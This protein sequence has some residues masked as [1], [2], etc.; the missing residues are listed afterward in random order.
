M[1][2]CLIVTL[3]VISASLAQSSDV[4]TKMAELYKIK[5]SIRSH[6]FERSRKE[7]EIQRIGIE[8][9]NQSE[10]IKALKKNSEDLK[11]SMRDRAVLLYK[12]KRSSQSESLFSIQSSQD[13]LKKS[14]LTQLFHK[15]DQK[16]SN[17]F[18]NIKNDL[19]KESQQFRNRLNYLSGLRKKSES[20]FQNLKSE[21]K[22][23]RIIINE[24]KS[25]SFD[26]LDLGSHFSSL[27]GQ[28]EPP[29]DRPSHVNFGYK[30][31][32]NSQLSFLSTGLYF[33]TIGGESVMSPY[34]GQVTFIG[35]LPYWGKILVLDHGD[36][37][38]TVYANLSDLSVRLGDQ[39]NPQQKLAHVSNKKY[40][41]KSGF[42]FEIR[43]YS[44]PQN[45]KEWFREGV[46]Q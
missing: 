33:E 35:E 19:S 11:K 13:L 38:F 6:V 41:R 8:L 36:S 34:Q 20:E 3:L 9:T 44:E 45:P 5:E 7:Q 15:Q 31:Q 26:N 17:Q 30:R 25:E 12:I 10:K 29:V 37:Y 27:R 22:R 28:M 14:Y 4:R 24:M 16:I 18:I 40:D 21:E 1:K 42:Y 32:K 46:I 2:I 23:Y 39:I 43:H